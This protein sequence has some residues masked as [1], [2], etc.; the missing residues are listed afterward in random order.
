MWITSLYFHIRLTDILYNYQLCY[1]KWN[2]CVCCTC[3]WCR[4][5]CCMLLIR[6]MCWKG[7]NKNLASFVTSQIKR[8]V[9]D[10]AENSFL[11]VKKNENDR[12]EAD[13]T[14]EDRLIDPNRSIQNRLD[15]TGLR[16][17]GFYTHHHDHW[18]LR[19][20]GFYTHHHDHCIALIHT[21][22]ER[23]MGLLQF[24]NLHKADTHP[25][26]TSQSYAEHC[27]TTRR[28]RNQFVAKDQLK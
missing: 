13:L 6:L 5:Q 21:H 17:V 14:G 7:E 9:I 4:R 11:S 23:G 8:L 16:F 10:R 12:L 2:C 15:R 24:Q 25:P 19:Y 1:C 27:H 20:L 26:A 3:V 18:D 22:Q 28:Q